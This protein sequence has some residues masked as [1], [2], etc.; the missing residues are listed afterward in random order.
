MPT[1]YERANELLRY[2][3]ESGELWWRIKFAPRVKLHKPA[4]FNDNGYRRLHFDR[5]CYLAHR[6]IWLLVHKTWPKEQ[7]D[8]VNGD[9]S[10]NR[11]YNLRCASYKENGRNKQLSRTKLH[12]YKG[13]YAK[14]NRWQASICVDRKQIYLGL[15]VSP[16]EARAAYE[17]AAL[18]L[19]GEF[20]NPSG[21]KGGASVLVAIHN[22]FAER[23]S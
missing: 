14:K 15:F 20:A 8:H 16:E 19:H 22:P 11:L 21:Y 17:A 9:R 5:H 7:I 13:V 4:G 1:T 10:D 3:P 18:R 12:A 23:V 2:E 6:I